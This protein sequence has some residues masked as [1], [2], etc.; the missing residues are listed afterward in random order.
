MRHAT[1]WSGALALSLFA[2]CAWAQNP[3]A[4]T[5]VMKAS[6][7]NAFE[8]EQASLALKQSS[9]Q[10]VKEFAH[11]MTTDHTKAEKKLE[12]A[13]KSANAL[14]APKLDEFHQD[15]VNVLRGVTGAAFDNAYIADQVQAHEDTASL[16]ETYG[17]DGDNPA[18][19]AWAAETLPTVKEHLD[20]IKA[21]SDQ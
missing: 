6:G 16:L 10:K 20:R 3:S 15:K 5:F 14:P 12:E 7:G 21:M 17:K 8:I 2:S 1:A 19:K 11:M 13:A 4:A 9:N 18:L